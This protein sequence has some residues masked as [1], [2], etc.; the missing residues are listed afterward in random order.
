[1]TRTDKVVPLDQ[2]AL[3]SAEAL[4]FLYMSLRTV[5]RSPSIDRSAHA[6]LFVDFSGVVPPALAI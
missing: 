6:M 1:M 3:P 2:L 4:N 5:H